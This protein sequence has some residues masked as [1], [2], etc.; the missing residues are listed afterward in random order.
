MAITHPT[1]DPPRRL[2][3]VPPAG[4]PNEVLLAELDECLG[5]IRRHADGMLAEFR[6]F[7]RV[8]VGAPPELTHDHT[9]ACH[10]KQHTQVLHEDGWWNVESAVTSDDD[11]TLTLTRTGFAPL[12]LTVEPGRLF[13]T[14]ELF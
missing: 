14:C 3:V 8:L 2:H 6:S 10:L 11:V 12:E 7:A 9:H 13:E 5:A 4:V 1:T